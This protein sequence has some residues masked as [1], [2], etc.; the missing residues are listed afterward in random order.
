MK[1]F[2]K[3]ALVGGLA[4]A[5]VLLA[6]AAIAGTGVGGVF[7][8][9]QTNKVNAPSSL[10][11][12]THAQNLQITN[13]GSGSALALKVGSG[14]PPMTVNSGVKVAKLNADKLDGLNASNLQRAYARTVVVTKGDSAASGNALKV[15]VAGITSAAADRRYLLK[16]EPGL[17][18]LGISKLQMKA[19][20]DIEGSGM[21]RRP[22]PARRGQLVRRHRRR[23]IELRAPAPDGRRHGRKRPIGRDRRPGRESVLGALGGGKG[24]GRRRKRSHP[25]ARR[26]RARGSVG[27]SFAATGGTNASPSLLGPMECDHE[28]LGS[29]R[30]R[31]LDQNWGIRQN[32]CNATPV[33]NSRIT[34]SG[35]R[36]RGGS[37]C[38]LFCIGAGPFV[39][40]R[41]SV[42]SGTTNSVHSACCMQTGIASSQLKGGALSSPFT[43][44]I[45]VWDEDY[46]AASA[47]AC[48]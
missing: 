34:S 28:P 38:G 29:Q 45:Y 16:V 35:I 18:D 25:R 26:R 44:C 19:F 48:P 36:H 42:I 11:G 33:M 3:G 13:T 30:L 5:V 41:N 10:K 21:T 32:R 9:G 8:L 6:T 31:R 46:A 40:I 23:S 20:V 22:L 17:Y 4:A 14:H 2:Y 15:A 1:T 43:A 12:S 7:N 27:S 39:E 37:L 24:I 47:T